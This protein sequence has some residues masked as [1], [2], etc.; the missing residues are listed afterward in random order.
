MT[1]EDPKDSTDE[2]SISLTEVQNGI[3]N[4]AINMYLEYCKEY[5][6]DVSKNLTAQY[7][8]SLASGFTQD[9]NDEGITDN[10]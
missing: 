3:F 4:L 6:Q 9:F 2:D 1:D 7:L 8:Q 5:T 10:A